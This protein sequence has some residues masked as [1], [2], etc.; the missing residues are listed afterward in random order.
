MYTE[1]AL[2]QIEMALGKRSESDMLGERINFI[3]SAVQTDEDENFYAGIITALAVIAQFD[4]EVMYREVINTLD[5]SKLIK[6]AKKNGELE[7]SGLI[8]YGYYKTLK[9]L[10]EEVPPFNFWVVTDFDEDMDMICIQTASRI[11]SLKWHHSAAKIPSLDVRG[12]WEKYNEI[13]E[14]SVIEFEIDKA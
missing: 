10:G 11:D 14:G 6:Y 5:L 3:C 1:S 12:I 2:Q 9:S 8:Q 4:N 7:F 13:Q